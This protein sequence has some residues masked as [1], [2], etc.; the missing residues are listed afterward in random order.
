M[1]V[2]FMLD[3]KMVGRWRRRTKDRLSLKL[4]VIREK[5]SLKWF[6]IREKVV[7][8]GGGG[9]VNHGYDYKRKD[10]EPVDSIAV[11]CQISYFNLNTRFTLPKFV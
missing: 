8:R 10:V 3:L 9:L 11:T 5:V 1:F 6:V 4:F 2:S 7:G